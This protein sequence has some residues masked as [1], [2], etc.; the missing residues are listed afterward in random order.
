MYVKIITNIVNKVNFFYCQVR[1]FVFDDNLLL[2][3]LS[4]LCSVRYGVRTFALVRKF[5]IEIII[6]LILL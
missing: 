4:D 6:T 3:Y 2:I 1:N 5:C